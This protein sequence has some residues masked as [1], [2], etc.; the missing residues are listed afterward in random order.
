[1]SKKYDVTTRTLYEPKPAEW[2]TFLS[3]P[4]PDPGLLQ[5]LDSNV[6][7]LSAEVDRAVRVGGPEPYIVHTEFFSARKVDLQERVFWY[8]TV[9]GEKHKLTAWSVIVL[10]RPASDGP[11]LTGVYEKSVPGRGVSTVFRYDVVR[12]WL[13]PPENLLGAGLS[14][15]P[16]APVSNVAPDQLEAVLTEVAERLKREADPELMEMLWTA[17]TV[18]LGLRHPHEQ[19]KALVEG[20]RDMLFGIHDIEESSVIQDILAKGEAKG[21]AEGE[22]KGRAEGAVDEA[23]NAFLRL[24]RKKLGTP[25]ERVLSLVRDL[26]DLD[27]INLMLDGLLDAERWEDLLPLLHG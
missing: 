19:V 3:L 9:L 23:R 7:T 20:V 1:M 12:V 18:L 25:D 8:N 27:R 5:V 4:F 22:A 11:E 26:R 15:L 21:R 13:E 6:S 14:L 2:L 16:L 10:L 24:G 17:T